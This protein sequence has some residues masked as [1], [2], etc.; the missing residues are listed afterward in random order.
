M[1]YLIVGICVVVVL[2]VV[3]LIIERNK[4]VVLKNNVDESFSNIDVVLK[5]RYDLIPNI[6]NSV[7]GYMEH[8]KALIEDIVKLRN[9]QYENMSINDKID[10][11]NNITKLFGLV[12]NYPILNTSQN[13]LD[14]QEKLSETENDIA[15]KRVEFNRKISEYNNSSRVF[16]MNIAAGLL[17]YKKLNFFE[18]TSKERENIKIIF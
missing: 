11:D 7:K 15:N 6:V 13:F 5:K 8:E 12:E 3:F 1:I 18:I 4:L 17:G 9:K 10:L 16:P 14:L 2:F